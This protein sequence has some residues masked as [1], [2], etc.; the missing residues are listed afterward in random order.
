MR[1]GDAAIQDRGAAEVL[2]KRAAEVGESGMSRERAS[3]FAGEEALDVS[4]F[5][6]KA[7]HPK[8]AEPEPNRIE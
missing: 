2:L 7:V 4:A 3:I 1:S 8:P 6:P 5:V